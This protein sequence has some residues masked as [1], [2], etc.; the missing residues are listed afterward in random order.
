MHKRSGFTLIELLV[1]IAIIALLLS[2]IVPSLHMAKRKA[3]MAVCLTDAKQIAT[4]WFMYQEEAKGKIPGSDP[5]RQYG[6]VRH[7]VDLGGATLSA[8]AATPVVTDE[9]EARGIEAG[10]LF[11]YLKS[12][13]VFHCPMDKRKSLFDGSDILR[14]FSMPACLNFRPD[15]NDQPQIKQYNE[16][17]G[18]GNKIMLLEEAEIRNYNLGSWS[19]GTPEW[20]GGSALLWWDPLAVTHGDSSTLGYCD[21]HAENHK[22]VDAFTRQRPEALART[23]PVATNYGMVAPPASEMTDIQFMHSVWA[24]RAKP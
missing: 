16:I 13:G 18:S 6:W 12:V 21:G 17:R 3:S 8:T 10:V 7:P 14:S 9:D 1:V 20:T 15:L 19:F 22:W 2:I 5:G 23:L 11:P 24:Y 4:A